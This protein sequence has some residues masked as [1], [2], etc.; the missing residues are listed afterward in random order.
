M[1]LAFDVIQVCRELDNI[2]YDP[3]KSGT[4]VHT[5]VP[6]AAPSLVVESA[7]VDGGARPNT[8][9]TPEKKHYV[10]RKQRSDL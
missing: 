5:E 8:V 9:H 2:G 1:W 6:T 7:I 10:S 3:S 4:K